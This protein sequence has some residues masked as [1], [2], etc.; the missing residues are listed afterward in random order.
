MIAGFL[1]RKVATLINRDFRFAKNQQTTN[2]TTIELNRTAVTDAGLEF[3]A[4]SCRNLT[5]I[6]LNRTAVTDAGLEFLAKSCRNLTTIY[7][8][9]TAV[10][11]AG[12]NELRKARPKI[13]IY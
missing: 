10:T 5:T 3:L 7:L 11:D 9:S 2:L 4:K 6:D 13:E 12:K 8:D 1:P